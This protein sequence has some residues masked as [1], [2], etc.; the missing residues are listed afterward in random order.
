MRG[1]EKLI[2]KDSKYDRTGRSG[3]IKLQYSRCLLRKTKQQLGSSLPSIVHLPNLI[4]CND[5]RSISVI[6]HS[7][8]SY[9][10]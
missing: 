9:F 10:Q 5:G 4:N 8:I 3:I 7:K 1:Q 2:S 6:S